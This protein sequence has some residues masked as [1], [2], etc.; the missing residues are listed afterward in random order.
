MDKSVQEF[1]SYL[2]RR[3][4]GRSTVKH[5]VS[6]LQIFLRFADKPLVD[7]G[8]IDI[9]A[10]V[11]EQLSHKLAATTINRRLASLH[12]LF[13]FLADETGEDVR[14]NPVTWQRHR[15]KEGKPLPRDVSNST[16][17]QLFAYIDDPRDQLMFGIM[18]WAGLRVG[19]VAKLEVSD[20]IRSP[21]SSGMARLRVRGKGQKERIVP[22]TRELVAQW[23]EWLAQ[24]PEG[25]TSALFVTRQKKGITVRGIQDRLA[26]YCEQAGVRF[27][28]HQLRHTF[29]RLM[30]E[31]KMPVTSLSK[32]LG[33][34]QVS[35]TQVYIAGA[36]VDVREELEAALE[37]LSAPLP[38]S[39]GSDPRRPSHS[40]E[41]P[42]PPIAVEKEK[43]PLDLGNSWG[44][45]PAWLTERLNDYLTCQ[46]HRWKTSQMHHHARARANALRPIWNWLTKERGVSSF[47]TLTRQDIQAYIDVRLADVAASTLNRQLRDL[48][49]FLCFL[50]D[51][52]ESIPPGVF[53]LKRIQEKKPLPRYLAEGEYQRLEQQVVAA[54]AGGSRE[55]RLDRAW[56]YLLAHTGVRLGELCDLQLGDL[57]LPGQRLAVR[58]GKGLRDRVVPLSGTVCQVL[59]D[60]LDVRGVAETNH[61]LIYRQKQIKGTLVQARLG[62]YGAA[63]EIEV[64]PHRMRHTLATRLV[65]AGMDVVSLQRL[66]GHEKL[67]TTMI[68][69]HVHDTTMARDFEQAVKHLIIDQRDLPDSADFP[70][71]SLAEELFS[72]ALTFAS[73]STQAPNCV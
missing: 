31:G 33:H 26:H 5:Y 10:F 14:P 6:D 63:V 60:Y 57:D 19:E 45:L 37:R 43:A 12:H 41:E 58:E 64:S 42:A 59:S 36:A 28:C 50:E 71:R 66:L 23:D 16:V 39:S 8:R 70:A 24:R 44:D 15:V 2:K 20:L 61:L 52:G 9:N 55:D 4:P 47:A 34:A 1:E 18:C 46:Q 25:L 21:S 48:W 54:T 51:H 49:A 13:E 38:G 35:T 17:E 65:N 73:L 30:V 69:A 7:I 72:H 27:S 68:Y 29:A 32:M 53:R 11:E 67:D 56:F 40:R 62:R 22:L 3:Y